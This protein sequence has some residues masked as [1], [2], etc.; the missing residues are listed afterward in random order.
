[1]PSKKR[2]GRDWEFKVSRKFLDRD[3]LT[4][5]AK[6]LA[7]CLRG[8]ANKDGYASPSLPQIARRSGLHVETVTKYLDE[9][10]AKEV[11]EWT[12]I[13]DEKGHRR[14]R[15]FLGVKMPTSIGDAIPLGPWGATPPINKYQ[16]NTAPHLNGHAVD[17]AE[18]LYDYDLN[19]TP[20]RPTKRKTGVESP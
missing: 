17:P 10:K 8:W 3:D 4:A 7:V 15:Y 2:S 14:R 9:L 6:W 20:K 16:C 5:N 18:T 19:F 12:S 1:M 13:R 11:I